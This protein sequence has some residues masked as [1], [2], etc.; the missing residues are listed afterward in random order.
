MSERATGSDEQRERKFGKVEYR[1]GTLSY[2]GSP[3]DKWLLNVSDIAV[4]GEYSN[5]NGPF[6]PDYFHVYVTRDLSWH[7]LPWDAV[8]GEAAVQA[9]GRELGFEPSYTLLMSTRFASCIAW[10]DNLVGRPLFQFTPPARKWY[11]WI[12]G[13]PWSVRVQLSPSVVEYLRQ[14]REHSE[15]PG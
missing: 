9:V 7:E 13:G 12:I 8:G 5:E 10:P 14:R 6:A 3:H 4:V 2:D 15:M 1:D 11:H